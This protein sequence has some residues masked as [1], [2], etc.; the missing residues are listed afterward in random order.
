MAS[1]MSS[2]RCSSHHLPCS[3]KTGSTPLVPDHTALPEPGIWPGTN[4]WLQ[5]IQSPA[6]REEQQMF[7]A[8]FRIT[9]LVKSDGKDGS[10]GWSG[11]SHGCQG[12]CWH[13]SQVFMPQQL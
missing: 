7:E 6:R 1:C 9:A 13:C 12:K 5:F 3:K 10:L 4:G 8:I 2:T 11:R